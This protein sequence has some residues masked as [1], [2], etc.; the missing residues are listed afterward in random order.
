MC[1]QHEDKEGEREREALHT[2]NP[3]TLWNPI[4]LEQEQRETESHK[5]VT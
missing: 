4:L 1:E 3:Q 5:N 2:L